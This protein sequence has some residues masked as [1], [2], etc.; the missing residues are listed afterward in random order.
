VLETPVVDV[1]P[2]DPTLLE[3]VVL[4]GTEVVVEE[5]A[6]DVDEVVVVVDVVVD[7]VG[8][9]SVVGGLS[10]IFSTVVPPPAWPKRSAN[11]RPAMSSTTVRK[12]RENTKTPAIV[13]A[14]TRHDRLGRGPRGRG[15]TGI[16]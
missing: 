12:R 2:V 1:A 3:D 10:K 7:V 8:G 6:V 5:D 11:G 16:C 4:P 15:G 9:G 14:M 13:P